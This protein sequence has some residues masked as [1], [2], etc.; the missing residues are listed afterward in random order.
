MNAMRKRDLALI[1]ILLAL[2]IA[3]PYI[4]DWFAALPLWR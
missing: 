1:L 2:C 4:V 3:A